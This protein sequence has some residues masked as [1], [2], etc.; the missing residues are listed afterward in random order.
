MTKQQREA[1][2]LSRATTSQTVSNYPA[3]I[4]GFVAKGIPEAE[5]QPRENVLT[6]DAWR[7]IGR[8]VQKGE[9]GVKVVTYSE[10]TVTDQE[11]GKEVT[12][13]IRRPWFTTVFHI[14]Q[15]D[16]Q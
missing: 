11:N 8:Q 10:R 12:R 13:T 7:A 9:H 3:I 1:E 4:S 6:Y 2:A 16:T 14:S 5:I 15:T